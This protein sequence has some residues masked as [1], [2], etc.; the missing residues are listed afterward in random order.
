MIAADEK[1]LFIDGRRRRGNIR[2]KTS[3]GVWCRCLWDRSQ[4]SSV[5]LGL[6]EL[7]VTA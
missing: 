2:C 6:F 5:P 3:D 4:W 7:E 1:I